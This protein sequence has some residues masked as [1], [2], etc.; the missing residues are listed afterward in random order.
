MTEVLCA[1]VSKYGTNYGQEKKNVR[2]NVGYSET[3]AIGEFTFDDGVTAKDIVDWQLTDDA[4]IL[5]S[6]FDMKDMR[7]D[8]PA[9]TVEK[10]SA[11]SKLSVGLKP[12][13]GVLRV[14]KDNRSLELDAKIYSPF[15]IGP[16]HEDFKVRVKTALFDMKM[17]PRGRGTTQARVTLELETVWD[18]YVAAELASWDE[19]EQV[20]FQLD[21]EA[22]TIFNGNLLPTLQADEGTEKIVSGGRLAALLAGRQALVELSPKHDRAWQQ[23]TWLAKLEPFLAM[24]SKQLSFKLDTPR[25]VSCCDI[26]AFVVFELG[27]FFYSVNLAFPV[28]HQ[29]VQDDQWQLYFD[30]FEVLNLKRFKTEYTNMRRIAQQEFDTLVEGRQQCCVAVGTGDLI[31]W[32]SED[33]ERTF[34]TLHEPD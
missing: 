29:N 22:G 9:S 19:N 4:Q 28:R 27:D 11:G 31:D 33:Q 1:H 26:L 13:E 10:P 7:F 6:N 16:E 23:I 34:I 25:D 2:E 5:L 30:A 14:T 21:C 3:R 12:R 32:F 17:S 18:H 24:P 15:L 20:D 8:I